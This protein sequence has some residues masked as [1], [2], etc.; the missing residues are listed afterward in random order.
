MKTKTDIIETFRE[1]QKKQ[2]TI[3]NITCAVDGIF[4]MAAPAALLQGQKQIELV[5][6][7]F[8]IQDV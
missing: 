3:I 6:T 8:R 2:A 7:G 5:E 4:A 1:T